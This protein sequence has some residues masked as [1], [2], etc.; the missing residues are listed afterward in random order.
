MV[1]TLLRH[2]HDAPTSGHF[3]VDKTLEKTRQMAWWCSMKE[4]IKLWIQ[5]C[6][7]CQRF[8]TRTTSS[9]APLKPIV[10]TRLGE[11][12]AADIAILPISSKGNRYMLVMMEYLSKW[13]VTVV[14]P[15]FDSDHMAHAILYEIVFKIRLPERLI[16]DNGSNFVSDAMKNVCARLGIKRSMTSVESPQTDGLVEGMNRTLK[17]SL[18]MAVDKEPHLW[19]EYLQFVTFAYNT[20]KQASTGFSPFQVLYGREA[21]LPLDKDLV[22]VS[23]TY[24]TETWINYLNK[25]IPILHGQVIENIK[26]ACGIY[27]CNKVIM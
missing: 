6:E 20:S 25:Y 3:G 17:T 10:P 22:V 27:T 23:K 26:R 4:D 21:V 1:K 19:D 2:V 7:K 15:S 8:K 5:H 13:V 16:T 24:E 11:I 12:W 9:V 18:A 14:L